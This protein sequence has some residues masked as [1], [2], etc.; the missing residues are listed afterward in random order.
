MKAQFRK[1]IEQFWKGSLNEEEQRRLLADLVEQE[2]KLKTELREEFE[3]GAIGNEE[4][5]TEERYAEILTQV[6]QKMGVVKSLPKSRIAFRP[7]AAAASVFICLGLGAYLFLS[8]DTA[9]IDPSDKE[10][11]VVMDTMHII[12]NESVDK[13]AFLP[14]GSTLILSS[15]SKLS[16]NTGYGISNR[17][18]MLSGKARFQVVKDTLRPFVVL[19][20]GYTT[21]ALG[22][23]FTVDTQSEEMVKVLLLS[24]KIVVKA[25]SASAVA[26]EDQYMK[27]GEEL[28]IHVKDRSVERKTLLQKTVLP[29]THANITLAPQKQLPTAL[30]FED[31]PLE[32][33]FGSIA[34]H[35]NVSIKIGKIKL[36]G[37][38][39]TGD[40]SPEESI[41]VMLQI[42][43]QMNGLT[44]RED[45]N[46]IW[47]EQ[48]GTAK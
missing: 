29:S 26:M 18:L 10:K 25:T 28:Q 16:Y 21:T 34:R 8:R 36:E 33:V 14:D 35:K 27:P 22:T 31:I 46:T 37:L 9:P 41:Q 45:G 44:Y 11:Y 48:S 17:A 20:N 13:K 12:N 47:I 19:A 24:G 23:D 4:L 38:S 2:E 32:E 1:Y 39:F 5:W 43:C 6:H 15:R 30:H 7:W 40:F 42:V 3:H